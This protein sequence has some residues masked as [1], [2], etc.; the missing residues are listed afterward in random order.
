MVCTCLHDNNLMHLMLTRRLSLHAQH[1]HLTVHLTVHLVVHLAVH[2][3]GAP[4]QPTSPSTANGD[5]I[6]NQQFDDTVHKPQNVKG[7]SGMSASVTVAC[8]WKLNHQMAELRTHT[9]LLLTLLRLLQL[10]L[11]LPV[12]LRLWLLLWLLWL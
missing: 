10:R 1:V 7:S 9:A 2:C 12:P 4:C 6:L 5:S 8:P 11:P 3:C